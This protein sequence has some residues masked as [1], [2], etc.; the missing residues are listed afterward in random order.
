MSLAREGNFFFLNST[1]FYVHLFWWKREQRDLPF[2][3]SLLAKSLPNSVAWNL[4][5]ASHTSDN[6]PATKGIIWYC[7]SLHEQGAE[8]KS[9]NQ[10]VSLGTLMYDTGIYIGIVT[11]HPNASPGFAF[12]ERSLHCDLCKLTSSSMCLRFNYDHSSIF[13]DFYI[14]WAISVFICPI[15][16]FPLKLLL[17]I[18]LELIA[19][20][21]P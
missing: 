14:R 19:P 7:D 3:D 18:S 8:S 13:K 21:S 2:T 20:R 6:D 12:M 10:D 4:T 11:T 17:R 1:Y 5:Q 9:C 15:S 16:T